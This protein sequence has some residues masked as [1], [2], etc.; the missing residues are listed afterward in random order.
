M[1]RCKVTLAQIADLNTLYRAFWRVAQGK[2]RRPEVRAFEENLDARLTALS[3][4]ILSGAVRVG[5]QRKFRI[6]DPKPREISAPCFR[7][8]VLHHAII[9]HIGPT[10]EKTA[11]FD[12]Y[13]CRKN[14][15]TI[16]A[17]Q[18]AQ[19]HA[20]RFPWY[21]QIDIKRYFKSI[22]HA[23]LKTLLRRR[24]KHEPLLELLDKIIEA[25]ADGPGRGL[26]IGA[27]T[28]Q[29]FANFYLGGFDRFFLERCKV[30][31]MLRYMDDVVWWTHEKAHAELVLQQAANFLKSERALTIKAGYKVQRSKA[32]IHLC[33]FH[34]LP[35]RIRLGR[36]RR[37]LY[38]Q[39]WKHWEKQYREGKI[40]ERQLQ[41]GYEGAR[42]LTLFAD[43]RAWRQRLHR[44]AS[45]VELG[46]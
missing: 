39:T 31:A 38:V 36:R 3:R 28:S 7:E 29:T 15:G 25:G 12:S 1:K 2:R 14:K 5:R 43:A 20:R 21:A 30:A 22:D 10:L 9:E 41:I 11:V 37:K 19:H 40:S 16:K 26:P 45:E 4:E 42:S 34:I 13:A 8:R 32:G 27:L 35:G 33:G 46:F 6:F 24:L 23:I 44:Q 18:R 17:V